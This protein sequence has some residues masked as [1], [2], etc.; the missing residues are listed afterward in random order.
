MRVGL[1]RKAKK[2]TP[3][4]Q[5]M[6]D[7]L[8]EQDASIKLAFNQFLEV[9]SSDEVIKQIN[10]LI[11]DGNIEAALEI[12]DQQIIR[13][14]GIIPTSFSSAG[15]A[16]S[17]IY[18]EAI[19]TPVVGISFDPSDEVAANIM[20]TQRLQFVQQITDKQR[21]SI[22]Q[23]L[24]RQ[25]SEGAGPRKTAAAFRDAI[26]L[27]ANQEQ[28]VTNFRALLES[29]SKEALNRDLR[30]RRFDRSIRNAKDKPLTEEQIDRMVDRYRER[31]RQYRAETIARTESTRVVG[32]ASKEAARQIEEEN[33]IKLDRTWNTTQDGRQRD[34][35]DVMNG[36]KRGVDDLFIDGDGNLLRFPGDPEAPEETTI[37]CRCVLTV[38]VASE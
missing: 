8:N 13:M 32:A 24:T 37:N 31:Y 11:T 34:I 6:L 4:A 17:L 26:G 15:A 35:H 38:R 12:V 14:S 21:A 29:G 18:N 5:K 16:A 36:Q 2:L 10:K 27:T 28:A 9:M 22:R 7:L 25:F 3:D 19:K 23:A 1:I 20:R 33:N 30:D